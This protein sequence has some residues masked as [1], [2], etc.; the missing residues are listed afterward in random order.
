MAIKN[1]NAVIYPTCVAL[2]QLVQCKLN[3]FTLCTGDA[4]VM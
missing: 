3:E 2:K 1:Q 4:E